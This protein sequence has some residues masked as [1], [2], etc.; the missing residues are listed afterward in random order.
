MTEVKRHH[1]VTRDASG[2]IPASVFVFPYGAK[3]AWGTR[4]SVS[5]SLAKSTPSAGSLHSVKRFSDANSVE[6]DAKFKF[7]FRKITIVKLKFN[8]IFCFIT[9]YPLLK[10][11]LM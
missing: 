6:S 9:L 1:D 11:G 10:M 5:V 3:F 7:R 8:R 2:F 4:S